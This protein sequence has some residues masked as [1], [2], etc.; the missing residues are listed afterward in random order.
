MTC[1]LQSLEV[2]HSSQVHWKTPQVEA[3]TCSDLFQSFPSVFVGLLQLRNFLLPDLLSPSLPRAASSFASRLAC[4]AQ[5]RGKLQ[6][7]VDGGSAWVLAWVLLL[8]IVMGDEVDEAKTCSLH[9]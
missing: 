1:I 7:I 9:I 8:V 5:R 6:A 4:C 2:Y 3:W